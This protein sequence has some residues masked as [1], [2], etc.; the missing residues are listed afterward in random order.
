[1]VHTIAC[2]HELSD[3]KPGRRHRCRPTTGGSGRVHSGFDSFD[4]FLDESPWTVETHDDFEEIP[5]ARFDEYVAEHT[6]F[7]TW[8]AML[9]TAGRQWVIEQQE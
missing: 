6:T 2:D 7:D 9:S 1:V 4:Q 8:E 5:T 3:P